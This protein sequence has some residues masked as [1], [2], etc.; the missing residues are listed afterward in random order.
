MTVR[1][2]ADRGRLNPNPVLSH[3]LIHEKLN[4][5]RKDNNALSVLAYVFCE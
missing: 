5:Y 4:D 1:S 3:V 2:H